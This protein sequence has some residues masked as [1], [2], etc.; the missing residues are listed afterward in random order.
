MKF[1]LSC[2]SNTDH[3]FE[4]YPQIKENF[5]TE[6]EHWTDTRKDLWGK[7]INIKHDYHY[8]FIKNVKDLLKLK[9]VTKQDLVICDDIFHPNMFKIIIYDDYLE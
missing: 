5:T 2:A 6:E 3:I 4:K 1:S 9:E 8:I 7:L